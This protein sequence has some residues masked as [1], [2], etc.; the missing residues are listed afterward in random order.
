M[1]MQGTHSATAGDRLTWLSEDDLYKR[2]RSAPSDEHQ[3]QIEQLRNINQINT[4]E[5]RQLLGQLPYMVCARFN[6]MS[7][8][9]EQFVWTEHLCLEVPVPSFTSGD[10]YRAWRST[11][12]RG[13]NAA[14]AFLSATEERLLIIFNLRKPC[15]DRELFRLFYR[16]FANR[17]FDQRHIDYIPSHPET[18]PAKPIC[19]GIDPDTY[20]CIGVRPVDINEYINA[21][22]LDSM[23]DKLQ[24]QRKAS[25]AKKSAPKEKSAPIGDDAMSKIKSILSCGKP[26]ANRKSAARINEGL[27]MMDDKMEELAQYLTEGGIQLHDVQLLKAGRKLYL[28]VGEC[29]IVL[30]VLFDGDLNAAVHCAQGTDADQRWCGIAQRL[31][32]QFVSQ[33]IV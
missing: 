27:A 23:H 1:F 26:T 3:H 18:D 6:P 19:I 28:S 8:R 15:R 31:V 10:D 22:S 7:Y 20:Y 17:F 13:S 16:E 4:T 14:M 9:V 2:L 30:N 33:N 5:A 25:K 11:L 12:I 29:S 32:Q 24:E 21:A